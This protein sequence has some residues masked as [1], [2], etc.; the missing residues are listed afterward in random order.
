MT[1]WLGRIRRKLIDKRGGY[2][3][4]SSSEVAGK[5][6]FDATNELEAALV[7]AATDATSQAAF[8][9]LLLRAPL[10]AVALDGPDPATGES[11]GAGQLAIATVRSPEGKQ[12]P[13]LFTSAARAREVFLDDARVIK[14]DADDILHRA[15]NQGAV[16]NPGLGYGIYWDAAALAALLSIPLQRSVPRGSN[17]QLSV[18]H[19]LP[20]ELIDRLT[21]ILE[22]D[23][24]IDEAWLALA[25]WTDAS[26]AAWYLDL[27]STETGDDLAQ[28]LSKALRDVPMHGLPLDIVVTQPGGA[29]GIGLSVKPPAL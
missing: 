20:L 12:L 2:P 21:T 28:M 6:S 8:N 29:I 14:M 3:L 7:A 10:F 4:S 15:A 16:L 26:E 23:S 19:D 24:R 9:Y 1:T 17:M 13:A 11:L 18:P 5:A 22:Q 25:N 27:R